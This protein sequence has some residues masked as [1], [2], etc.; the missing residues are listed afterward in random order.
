MYIILFFVGF[1]RVAG[2]TAPLLKQS[3]ADICVLHDT[4][5]NNEENETDKGKYESKEENYWTTFSGSD[6]SSRFEK[7][8]TALANRLLEHAPEPALQPPNAV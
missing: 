1:C 7:H 4:E 3:A 5:C 8:Y 2:I 6:D